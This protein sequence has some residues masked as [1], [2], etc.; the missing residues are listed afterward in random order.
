M[1]NTTRKIMI[2]Y[3]FKTLFCVTIL[4][5]IILTVIIYFLY[6]EISILQ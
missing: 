1:D 4:M 3:H 5:L 2:R 6:N